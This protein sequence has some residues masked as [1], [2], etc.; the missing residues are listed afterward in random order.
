LYRAATRSFHS[1]SILRHL[2]TVHASLGEFELASKAL[3]SY[4]EIVT[5]SKSRAEKSGQP[6]PGLDSDE[7]MLQ[8]VAAGIDML[9]RYGRQKEATRAQELASYLVEWLDSH[10]SQTQNTQGLEDNNAQGNHTSTVAPHFVALA[11]KAI[12]LSSANWSHFTL[13]SSE[14]EDLHKSAASHL[15][16]ALMCD[17]VDDD[18]PSIL[19]ALSAILA[20]TRDIDGAIATIKNALSN[21]SKVAIHSTRGQVD[22]KDSQ[23][24]TLAKIGLVQCWHLL[25]LLLSARQEFDK[26]EAS[27]EAAIDVFDEYT[28]LQGELDLKQLSVLDKK[29]ILE[30]KM[31]SI[32]LS[33]LNDGPEVAVNGAGEL[34]S[35]YS[36]IF[37]TEQRVVIR[38]TKQQDAPK[39]VTGHR[40]V[41]ESIF[42]R[43]HKDSKTS[44][45]DGAA[46]ESVLTTRISVDTT[47]P[48]TIAI[49]D[50]D[51]VPSSTAHSNRV[52]RRPSHKLQK[53]PS[54]KSVGRSRHASPARTASVKKA[55]PVE[56]NGGPP[57]RRRGSSASQPYEVGLALSDDMPETMSPPRLPPINVE[58]S[59]YEQAIMLQGTQPAKARRP[60]FD[61]ITPKF[62][63]IVQERYAL[64]LL[65]HIWI[66]ISGLY[67]KANM[68][69]DARSAINEALQ[70]AQKIETFAAANHS[71]S[72]SFQ[73][74]A[75]G[76]APSSD[77]IFADAYAELGQLYVE[78]GNP[79]EAMANFEL[80]V[81][82]FADHPLAIVGLS[83]IL[84]DI[85]TK[86][87]P[88]YPKEP[89]PA[90]EYIEIPGKATQSSEPI[91]WNV[92]PLPDQKQNRLSSSPEKKDIPT[93][94]EDKDDLSKAAAPLEPAKESRTAPEVLD[95]LW[96]RDRAYGLLSTLTKLGTSWDNSEAW[97]ALARAY[98][99]SGQ[100]EK[101]QDLLWWVV[102]LEEKRP[103]RPWSC[104]GQG[105]SV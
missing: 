56:G 7:S 25:A 69:D 11:H 90:Q 17:S 105:Y 45:P 87:I 9:C 67:R 12:A 46:A 36:K 93:S 22:L 39:P 10:V 23:S 44:I 29:R 33:D 50:G 53:R 101:A 72:R 81:A 42:G 88:P 13:Q 26:A 102:E 37:G 99:E 80:A 15:R 76:G 40:S 58:G 75:V 66:F 77:Q 68:V 100:P 70:L 6:E 31:T 103:V 91:L 73:L 83:T 71:S 86:A 96:A 94:E 57:Q 78:Q 2:L 51:N 4:L 97:F 95:R 48:P 62:S 89:S 28:K 19:Y 5:K 54:Q 98:E 24:R 85:Y 20:E 34:L 63:I 35:L 61:I 21:Q 47:R 41:R 55:A 92:N 43:H 14:R 65:S 18:D 30:A 52:S 38:S 79:Y 59:P 84:I 104:L 32:A 82:Y 74:S 1:N 3:D 60:L 27:C 49:N 8:T 64:T 16:Q